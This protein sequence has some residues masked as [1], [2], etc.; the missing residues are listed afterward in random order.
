MAFYRRRGQRIVRRL[1]RLPCPVNS[2]FELHYYDPTLPDDY[3]KQQLCVK[4][5]TFQVLLNIL[6]PHV[7]RQDTTMHEVS[8]DGFDRSFCFMAL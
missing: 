5:P 7:K 4:K 1:W 8:N 6:A 2:W 3:F